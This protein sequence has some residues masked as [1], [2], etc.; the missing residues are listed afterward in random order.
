MEELLGFE[1]KLDALSV[2]PS[3]VSPDQA[4]EIEKI[5]G[6]DLSFDV[7]RYFGRSFVSDRPE[8]RFTQAEA[9]ALT[10]LLVTTCKA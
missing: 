7:S 6:A 9:V 2:H 3:Q 1:I 10:T 5:V 8:R 4:I